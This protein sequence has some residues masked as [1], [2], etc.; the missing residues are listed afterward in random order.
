MKQS[1]PLFAMILGLQ[2]QLVAVHA[3]DDLIPMTAEQIA[4]QDIQ[5]ARPEPAVRF[6]SDKLPAE[7]V[8]PNA[9]R[10]IISAPQSGLLEV[11][12]VAA[13]ETVAKD[14]AVARIQSPD[15]IELQSELLQ[16][17]T[18]L[19][20]AKSNLDRDEQ[21][22]K[23]GIIAERRYLES[24]SQYRELVALMEQRR[25]TLR[26][27]GMSSTAIDTLERK[28]ELSD[29][30][31]VKAPIEGV[32]MEQM[33]VAGQR[34]EAATALY[35]IARLE[36]LWLEIHIPLQRAREIRNGDEVRVTGTDAEGRIITIGSEVHTADQGILLRAEI[37]KGASNLRPGQFVQ[38]IVLCKCDEPNSYALPRSAIV[39][40]GQRTLVFVQVENGFIA[41]DVTLQQESGN[42][43]IVTGELDTGS[44]VVTSGTATLKAALSGIGGDA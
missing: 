22:H 12:L 37:D 29:S 42:Y 39:R 21:L 32:I 17:Q 40:I 3:A 6:A 15:L 13:G 1:V 41:R 9:Q 24:R 23:E 10:R 36:P 28:Q 11:M 31:E 19:H 8:V 43:S 44:V 30:L 20:L 7:V 14:Q 26:L 35:R 34:V 5:T 38:A 27:A 2:L 4:R 18:R 16:T 33:A 25:Q